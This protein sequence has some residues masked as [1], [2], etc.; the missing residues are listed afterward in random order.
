MRTTSSLGLRLV[1]LE[2]RFEYAHPSSSPSGISLRRRR[3][4]KWC[5][6]PEEEGRPNGTRLVSQSVPLLLANAFCL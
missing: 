1:N 5:L 3:L 6:W 2:S 4:L